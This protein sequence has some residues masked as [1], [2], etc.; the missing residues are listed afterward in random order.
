MHCIITKQQQ[1]PAVA[2][3]NGGLAG[4]QDE[5][6]YCLSTDNQNLR[7]EESY[8]GLFMVYN[9]LVK[10]GSR[11]IPYS[12]RLNENKKVRADFEVDVLEAW[13]PDDAM[14]TPAP[15]A[16]EAP[17]NVS[18][19]GGVV[20]GNIILKEPPVY[21]LQAKLQRIQGSVVMAAVISRAGTVEDIEVIASPAP[22]LSE[23]AMEAVKHWKYKPYL[24]NGNPVAVD[25]MITVNF[26]FGTGPRP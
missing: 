3:K 11:T 5:Q 9:K 17:I 14:L 10:F 22:S 12:V 2:L 24:L 26:S 1:D 6:A 8:P 7:V 20:A 25:T 4:Q 13:K 21:P 16:T 15:D 18:V 19:S 23:A